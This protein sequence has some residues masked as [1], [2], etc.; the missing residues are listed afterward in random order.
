MRA[1]MGRPPGINQKGPIPGFTRKI[2]KPPSK[3]QAEQVDH[4]ALREIFIEGGVP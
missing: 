1:F 2:E 3:V 4:D